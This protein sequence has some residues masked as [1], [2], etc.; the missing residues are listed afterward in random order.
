MFFMDT[1]AY[2]N[3]KSRGR[4]YLW[5]EKNDASTLA[6]PTAF[7]TFKKTSKTGMSKC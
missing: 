5:Q 4:I 3:Y 6:I 2:Q 7:Y 1:G